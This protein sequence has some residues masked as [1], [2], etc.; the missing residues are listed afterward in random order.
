MI[1]SRR[2]TAHLL[3]E[4]VA[5]NEVAYQMCGGIIQFSLEE[6]VKV[7]EMENEEHEVQNNEL[8]SLIKNAN[9]CR[10]FNPRTD[11]CKGFEDLIEWSNGKDL[12]IIVNEELLLCIAPCDMEQVLAMV[13]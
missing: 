5:M 9:E 11:G 6:S 4:Y 7:S 3:S 10:V 1:N 2:I 12:L 13:A 8:L